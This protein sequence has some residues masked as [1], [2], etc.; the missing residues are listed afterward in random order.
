[1]FKAVLTALLVFGLHT[2]DSTWK[3]KV[4]DIFAFQACWEKKYVGDINTTYKCST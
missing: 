2:A 1:M 4:M 3:D